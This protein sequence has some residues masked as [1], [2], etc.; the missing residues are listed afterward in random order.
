MPEFFVKLKREKVFN[1]ISSGYMYIHA[2]L[3]E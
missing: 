3:Y 2:R 1:G